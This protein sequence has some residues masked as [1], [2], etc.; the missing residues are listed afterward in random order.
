MKVGPQRPLPSWNRNAILDRTTWVQV[1]DFGQNDG[2]ILRHDAL[3][4]LVQAD[5]RRISDQLDN[6]IH[7]VHGT[8]LGG[9]Q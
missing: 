1:L 4:D 8:T 9:L 3:G 2:A 5:E 6:R 7:V